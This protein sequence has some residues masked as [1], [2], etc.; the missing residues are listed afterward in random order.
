MHGEV[1][2]LN[3][4]V[5]TNISDHK[6]KQKKKGEKEVCNNIFFKCIPA[7]TTN[8]SVNKKNY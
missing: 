1:N 3:Q 7:K 6:M 5:F 4:N 8:L 2:C